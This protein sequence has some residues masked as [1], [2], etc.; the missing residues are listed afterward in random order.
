MAKSFGL[1]TPSKLF[2]QALMKSE[3]K[4]SSLHHRG[5]WSAT[6]QGRDVSEVL[7]PSGEMMNGDGLRD[8]DERGEHGDGLPSRHND[9]CDQVKWVRFER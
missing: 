5:R 9:A 7:V 8:E 4:T 1:L 3:T 2:H 6:A